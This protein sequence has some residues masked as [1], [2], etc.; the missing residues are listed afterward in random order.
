M[1][2]CTRYCQIVEGDMSEPC[3]CVELGLSCL[4]E[5][6]EIEYVEDEAPTEEQ[7][8]RRKILSFIVK[9]MFRPSTV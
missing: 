4:L 5:Q 9:R 3:Q 2:I 7:P 1:T 6:P 8:K